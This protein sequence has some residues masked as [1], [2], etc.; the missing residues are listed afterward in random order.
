MKQGS[1]W[2]SVT[3]LIQ[4]EHLNS[5]MTHKVLVDYIDELL[6]AIKIEEA[7]K[8]NHCILYKVTK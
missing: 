4:R 3:S 1:A 8:C 2:D 6:T 5:E 7:K